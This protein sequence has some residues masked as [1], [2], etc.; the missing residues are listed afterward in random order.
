MISRNQVKFLHS[1]RLKKF[2]DINRAFVV[3]GVKMVDELLRSEYR[4]LE[5]YAT[6]P[7]I[8][9]N[10]RL[11]QEKHVSCQEIDDSELGKVSNL[12]TPN[13]VI[14]IASMPVT[15]NPDPKTFGQ[16]VLILDRIQDPGNFGTIIR[17]ADWFG[18]SHIICSEDTADRFNPKVI[19]A[20]MGSV[21]RVSVHYTGLLNYIQGSLAGWSIYAASAEGENLYNEDLAFP[22]AIVIG[23]ESQGISLAVMSLAGI[24]L[25]IPRFGNAESL[26]ASVATGIFLSEFIRRH[27]TG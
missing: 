21:F 20:T 4:I 14:A 17:T 2:R 6:S 19:Q 11:C 22:A 24:K 10:L 13:E 9:K 15:D 23:N 16:L 25:G 27:Y 12:T 3:E 8:S 26:N 7:W 5:V 1:L 18:I